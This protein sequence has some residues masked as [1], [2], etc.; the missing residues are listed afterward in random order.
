NVVRLAD[1]AL[2]SRVAERVVAVSEYVRQLVVRRLRV[3]PERTR[4][5]YNAVPVASF[6][7]AGEPERTS[8]RR[9]LAL[10]TDDIAIVTVGHVVPNKGQRLLIE[11]LP[12]LVKR[13]PR[14]RL[15]VVGDGVDRSRLQQRAHELGVSEHVR[16]LGLRPDVPRILGAADMFALASCYEGLPLSVVEAMAASLPCVLSPIPPHLELRDRIAAVDGQGSDRM[17]AGASPPPAWAD[18]LAALANDAKAREALGSRSQLAA[19]R[20]FDV[21]VT[22]PALALVFSEAIESFN[23]SRRH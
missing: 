16:W 9:E 12:L 4:V 7:R 10:Q 2:S 19:H 14:V 8:I 1:I 17:I 13:S 5:V 23:G 3:P 11:A 18:A 6:G 21:H 15:L 22:A 20:H